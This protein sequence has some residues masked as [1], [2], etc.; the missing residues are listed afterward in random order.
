MEMFGRVNVYQNAKSKEKRLGEMID[1]VIRVLN[2]AWQIM[3]NSPNLPNFSCCQ[4]FQ[5]YSITN[6]Y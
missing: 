4:T 6:K 3:Y 2:L 1:L 5:L